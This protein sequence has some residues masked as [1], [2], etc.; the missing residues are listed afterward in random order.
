MKCNRAELAE[1]LGMSLPTI[2]AW[3]KEGMPIETRGGP[4]VPW[5]FDLAAVIK[6]HT[7][8]K[9][10]AAGADT[11]TDLAEIEKRTAIAK[12]EQQELAS[13][14]SKGEVAT[15][16]DFERAQA[17]VFA[18]IRTNVMNVPQRVV[19]QL[20]GETDETIFKQKLKAELTLALKAAAEAPLTLA[21]EDDVDE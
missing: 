12:M 7:D 16:R 20:L 11:P 21:E 2:D 4:G 13:A 1:Y 5:V 19:I 8:R 14:K 9:V 17:A 18:E 6:W 10:A 3:R 15:I